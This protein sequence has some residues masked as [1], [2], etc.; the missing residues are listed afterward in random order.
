MIRTKRKTVR[1][2]ELSSQHIFIFDSRPV[3]EIK[4]TDFGWG[5]GRVDHCVSAHVS[6]LKEVVF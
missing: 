5:M 3:N 2:R 6:N 1:Y 4:A